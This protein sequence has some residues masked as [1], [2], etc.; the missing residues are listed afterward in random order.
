MMQPYQS[1]ARNLAH[2]VSVYVPRALLPKARRY[3]EP[4][5]MSGID[6]TISKFILKGKYYCIRILHKRNHGTS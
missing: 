5:L 4:N 6:H 2:I 3:V 1:Q